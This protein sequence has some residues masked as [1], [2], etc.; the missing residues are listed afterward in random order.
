MSDEKPTRAIERAVEID[1]PIEAV[2]KA[3]SE[4][5]ELAKWFALDARVTPG[6]GGEV[7]LSWPGMEGASPISVWEPGKRLQTREEHG[8]VLMTVDW[9]LEAKGGKTLLR[10][11]HS[12]FGAD[13]AWDD[14]YDDT[15]RGWTVFVGNLVHYLERHRGSAV[16]QIMIPV[17]IE[18]AVDEA[19][20]RFMG[21]RGIALDTTALAAGGRYATTAATGDLLEGVLDLLLAPRAF[22]GTVT[23]WNDAMLRMEFQGGGPGKIQ[24]WF[25]IL[26]YGMP[27]ADV[28]ALRA[29]WTALLTPLF[30][31]AARS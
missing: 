3:I 26:T 4:G 18:V 7:W 11:V 14:Q 9:H 22:G 28:E 13:A 19:W 6:V 25:V 31:P 5:E 1:A 23:G 16:R 12:G 2:W 27:E 15:S 29:R 10:L 8:P 21:P 30:G 24:C 17:P 20:Q